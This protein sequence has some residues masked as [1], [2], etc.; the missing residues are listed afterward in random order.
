M[1][2]LI[3]AAGIGKRL[4]PLTKNIP[5]CLLKINQK[6]II[7]Y[8]LEA[9]D[10]NN[11]FDKFIVIGKEGNCWNDKTY[12]LLKLYPVQII[13]NS[14]N[15]QLDNTY[16]LLLGLK[17]IGKEDVIIVDGDIIF[18]RK[19]FLKLLNSRY[20]NALLSRPVKNINER[21]GRIKV[22]ISSRIIEIGESI[23][24]KPQLYMYSGIAKIG[25]ELNSYLQK[26]L[27]KHKKIVD[28][29]NEACK[30]F[31]IYNLTFN[32]NKNWVNINNIEEFRKARQI[33]EEKN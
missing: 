9:I 5:K 1:K 20:E 27:I 17:I 15:I 30:L 29:M 10:P 22:G 26:N 33:Y 16:S 12:K 14:R 7:E 8:I 6:L 13:Y 25:R 21:G 3:L 28:A 31:D 19:I 11:K 4:M 24:A 2:F 23:S 18:Q 32:D